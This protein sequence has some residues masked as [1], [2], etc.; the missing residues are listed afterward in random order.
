MDPNYFRPAAQCLRPE[1]AR[2]LT[3]TGQF[4]RNAPAAHQLRLFSA[5]DL[6][7]VARRAPRI[8]AVVAM[9]AFGGVARAATD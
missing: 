4:L 1:Q 3:S 6:F 9:L 2:F 7:L 8:L 5:S